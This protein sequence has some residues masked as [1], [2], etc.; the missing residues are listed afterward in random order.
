MLW[1]HPAAAVAV[2]VDF[3]FS[4]VGIYCVGMNRQYFVLIH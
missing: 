1:V 4:R 3:E 2:M